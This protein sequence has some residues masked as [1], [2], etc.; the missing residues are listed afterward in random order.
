MRAALRPDLGIVRHFVLN[1]LREFRTLCQRGQCGWASRRRGAAARPV[2]PSHSEPQ[3][4]KPSAETHSSFPGLSAIPSWL[5][6]LLHP[7]WGTRPPV[8]SFSGSLDRPDSRSACRP[9]L[10]PTQ[11]H[12]VC[13]PGSSAA[14]QPPVE[15]PSLPPHPSL[16]LQQN[17]PSKLSPLPLA[18]P[19]ALGTCF[20]PSS[21]L[22]EGQRA[23]NAVCSLISQDLSS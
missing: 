15:A 11:G 13:A 10:S 6:C 4:P 14:W 3:F 12:L 22:G 2:L 8:S 7:A 19:K 21:Q 5:H 9:G 18:A 16:T 20:H 1:L 23:L 17:A